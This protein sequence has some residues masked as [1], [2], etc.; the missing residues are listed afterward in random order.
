MLEPAFCTASMP[1][2]KMRRC[3]PLRIG[4]NG[5]SSGCSSLHLR[6]ATE[7]KCWRY[8]PYSNPKAAAQTICRTCCGSISFGRTPSWTNSFRS[9]RRAFRLPLISSGSG[10]A[11]T[12]AHTSGRTTFR[13][14]EKP[15]SCF[16][17]LSTFSL[18]A[19]LRRNERTAGV[20][21]I[22]AAA[23]AGTIACDARHKVSASMAS[24]R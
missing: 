1:P 2:S 24:T 21:E 22:S 16:S 6:G 18:A 19:Y 20:I 7:R 14:E 9:L 3:N 13:I 8:F 17:S 11:S 5:F 4:S 12:S 23:L 10:F 15:S